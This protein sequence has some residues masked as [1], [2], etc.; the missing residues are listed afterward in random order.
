MNRLCHVSLPRARGSKRSRSPNCWRSARSVPRAAFRPPK[1]MP[2]IANISK[3][4]ATDT[5][6]AS[7]CASCAASSKARPTISNCVQGRADLIARVHGEAPRLRCDGDA[8]GADRGADHRRIRKRRG[9]CEA[10]HPV[11]SQS[12]GRELPRSLRDLA[13]GASPGRRTGRADAGRQARRG[14]E[15]AADREGGGRAVQPQA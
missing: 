7:A 4:S 8:D 10:Q 5:T 9:L 3:R 13:A 14:C 6:R 11:A 1:P 12:D 2:G 15:A